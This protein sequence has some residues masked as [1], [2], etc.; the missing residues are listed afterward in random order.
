[1]SGTNQKTLTELRLGIIQVFCYCGE[2]LFRC[3]S[4]VLGVKVKVTCKKC[5][6]VATF[7]D[8]LN[9]VWDDPVLQEECQTKNT[10]GIAT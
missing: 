4:N 8:S 7:T 1:M 3:S 9:P 6:D 10:F 2:S 5:G